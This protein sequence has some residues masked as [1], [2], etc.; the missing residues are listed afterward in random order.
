MNRLAAGLRSGATDSPGRP[1]RCRW[2]APRRR[3]EGDVMPVEHDAAAWAGKR[4]Q[5]L[6][7]RAL[8]GAVVAD[9]RGDL[10]G[11]R[12]EIDAAQR[13][14]W[15]EMLVS[16][17]VRRIGRQRPA[18]PSPGC[19]RSVHSNAQLRQ[20]APARSDW[21]RRPAGAPSGGDQGGGDQDVAGARP[22]A[23][24]SSRR[25]TAWRAISSCPGAA[26]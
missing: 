10:A 3:I 17:W 18:R 15:P 13:F 25:R 8:A 21:T 12:L 5:D 1:S 22:V 26:W 11:A 9:Q 6:H 14:T 16:A 4:G 23:R 19:G 24:R 7:Q 20:A 2:H